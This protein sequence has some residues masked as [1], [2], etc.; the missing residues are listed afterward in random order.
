MRYQI[1]NEAKKKLG[2]TNAQL[3]EITGV[4][5]T[6]IEKIASGA[7]QNPK[8]CTLQALATPL[9]LTLDDFSDNPVHIGD[10]PYE[11]GLSPDE[12]ALVA[13][14]RT[15]NPTGQE[16]LRTTAQSLALNPDMA[17]QSP[18]SPPADR[19]A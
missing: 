5:L 12:S 6:T 3:S 4:T 8:I 10:G 17:A 2:I 16:V 11:D 15:L 1:I 18:L 13:T 9:G 7:N 19:L 14:Y